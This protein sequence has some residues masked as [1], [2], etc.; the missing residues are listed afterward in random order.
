M[1]ILYLYSLY[2]VVLLFILI[3][4]YSNKKA[5]PESCAFLLCVIY[6]L[7]TDED[8]FSECPMPPGRQYSTE[9]AAQGN[10]I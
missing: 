1:S 2:Y 4:I 6:H 9:P 8:L 7:W 10:C 5:Q 3:E